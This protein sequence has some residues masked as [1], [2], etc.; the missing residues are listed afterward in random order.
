MRSV[1]FVLIDVPVQDVVLLFLIYGLEGGEEKEGTA[2]W[3]SYPKHPDQVLYIELATWA[4]RGTKIEDDWDPGFEDALRRA[5]GANVPSVM[6]WADVSGRHP[7]D[8][9]VRFLADILLAHFK[10]YA[11]DDWFGYS[12][13][14]SLEEI[15]SG[16]QVDG[17]GFFDYNG[18]WE[19][20]KAHEHEAEAEHARQRAELEEQFGAASDDTTLSKMV[21]AGH[22]VEAI[23]RLRRRTGWA[24]RSY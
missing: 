1:W 14:W 3:F 4:N 24:L 13:A 17:L 21:A 5:I 16:K 18:W 7:G 22:K 6:V 8:S 12:H 19:K 20:H 10:G 2:W 11:F 9:E 23:V 15:E